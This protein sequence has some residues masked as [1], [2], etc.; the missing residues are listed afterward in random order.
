M[1]SLGLG[2][3]GARAKVAKEVLEEDYVR[4]QYAAFCLA[5]TDIPAAGFTEVQ[6]FIL[7]R[8]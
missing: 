8:V 6:V 1:K 4:P 5:D 2:F 7:G 3:G